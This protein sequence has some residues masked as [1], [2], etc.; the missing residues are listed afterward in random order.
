MSMPPQLTSYTVIRSVS[1][2]W[3]L[4]RHGSKWAL[5]EAK[6]RFW[7]T[8]SA[9]FSFNK[10]PIQTYDGAIE[11]KWITV[12]I[13][14]SLMTLMYWITLHK[15][16]SGKNLRCLAM[17]SAA[18]CAVLTINVPVVYMV[19]DQRVPFGPKKVEIFRAPPP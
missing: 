5:V 9:Y 6:I 18:S 8:L 11:T 10:C 2:I 1:T 14:V 13:C 16:Q 3:H 19:R 17:Y 12:C 7:I 15:M 4:H